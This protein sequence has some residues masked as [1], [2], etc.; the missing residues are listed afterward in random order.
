MTEA[1][2]H[3]I[4][5]TSVATFSS[6]VTQTDIQLRGCKVMRDA[7]VYLGTDGRVRLAANGLSPPKAIN[8]SLTRNRRNLIEMSRFITS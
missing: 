6:S 7:P 8:Q 1:V 4:Q 3:P 5:A 2:T